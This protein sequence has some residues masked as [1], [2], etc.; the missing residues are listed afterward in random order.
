MESKQSY[1][2]ILANKKNGTLYTGVTSNLKAR[3]WQHKNKLADGF[4][5]EYG[6]DML[7]WYEVHEEIEFAITREKRIKRWLRSWKIE[8]IE[9]ENPYWKDLFESL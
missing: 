7:V 3:I 5:K 8:L 2:Y 9:K 1:V 6:C 4:T